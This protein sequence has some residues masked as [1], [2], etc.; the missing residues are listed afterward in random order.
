MNPDESFTTPRRQSDAA[1]IDQLVQD[2]LAHNAVGQLRA[3]FE[4]SRRLPHYSPFNCLLLHIQNPEAHFVAP[5]DKWKK[6]K[7]TLKPGSRPLLILAPMHPVMFVFDVS[8]TEGEE[9]PPAVVA[10]MKSAFAVEGMVSAVTS[11]RHHKQCSKAA[12][13]IESTMMRPAMA[14]DI[15]RAAAGY[16][17]RLNARHNPTQQF[18]TLV[19]EVAHLFCGHLG[20]RT[21]EWWPDRSRELDI[22]TMELEAEA[23]AWLVCHRFQAMPASVSYLSGY[24]KDGQ[25]LPKFS[26]EAILVAAGAIE[27]MACG[28]LPARLRSQ[29]RKT[30]L[31]T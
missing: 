24:L 14:G 4:F 31:T 10:A 7:R 13:Q 29:K 25:E 18:A 16:R 30:K 22:K 9:L 5:L 21:D 28:R 19:H 23:V 20:Q 26:L 2:V 15:D 6:L 8:D 17:V 27:E 3:L 12:I 1:A 11:R